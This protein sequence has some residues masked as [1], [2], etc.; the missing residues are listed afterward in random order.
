MARATSSPALQFCR[1]REALHLSAG[2]KGSARRPRRA[3]GVQRSQCVLKL[4]TVVLGFD[5]SAVAVSAFCSAGAFVGVL[6]ARYDS[7]AHIR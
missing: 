7:R 4:C 3:S 2:A 5:C 1:R 6:P